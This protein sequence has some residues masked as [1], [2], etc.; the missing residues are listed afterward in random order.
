MKTL[1]DILKTLVDVLGIIGALVI[2]IGLILTG[3]KL[4][5]DE[6]WLRFIA[7]ISA[8][9]FLIYSIKEHWYD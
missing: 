2:I 1:V 7:Y 3:V 9:S 5:M 8:M 6:D 4:W